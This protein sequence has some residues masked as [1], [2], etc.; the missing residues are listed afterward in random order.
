MVS[1][2]RLSKKTNLELISTINE[3]EKCARK[4][5]VLIWKDIANRLARPQ[6]RWSNVNLYTIE[7]VAKPNETIIIP[8]KV[9]GTGNI[10]KKINIS[11]FSFSSTAEDKIINAGGKTMKITE[12]MSKKPKGSGIRII[13]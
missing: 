5:K 1:K 7:R 4:N 10:T 6:S 8:G 2:K 13:G 12:L 11:A 9:L 3:L